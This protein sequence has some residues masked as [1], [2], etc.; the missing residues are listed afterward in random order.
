MLFLP[1]SNYNNYSAISAK[2]IP[3]LSGVNLLPRV[4]AQ[5][6]PIHLPIAELTPDRINLFPHS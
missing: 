3:F 1:K 4:F 5:F 2:R 6:L